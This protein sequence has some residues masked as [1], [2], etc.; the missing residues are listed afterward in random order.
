[1]CTNN[2]ICG[3]TIKTII[4]VFDEEEVQKCVL[5]NGHKGRCSYKWTKY[6]L[7]V[8]G[9]NLKDI[10][11]IIDKIEKAS[12]S[13]NG[14]TAENSPIINRTLRYRARKEDGTKLIPVNGAEKR[15]L[16]EEGK[17]R[18]AVRKDE[19]ST[20]KNCQEIEKDLVCE[21]ISVLNKTNPHKCYFCGG[22]FTVD[23][24]IGKDRKSPTSAQHGHKE[25]LSDDKVN[26]VSGN[27]SWQHRK[28]NLMQSD[29][30]IEETYKYMK[31]AVKNLEEKFGF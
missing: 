31:M 10:E 13:T 11:R 25:P 5:E 4:N 23:D 9:Y 26:H 27:V 8:D 20:F 6:L 21:V 3:K 16:K 22:D 18:V 14:E 30:S 2:K 19:L 24:F 28:C 17:F 29:G 12:Y 15:I 1:M 7:K